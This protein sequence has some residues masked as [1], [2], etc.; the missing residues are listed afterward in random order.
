MIVFNQIVP[1]TPVRSHRKTPEQR[2]RSKNILYFLGRRQVCRAVF[3]STYGIS[4]A[5]IAYLV[6]RKSRDS[7]ALSPDRRGR[8]TPGNKTSPETE[9]SIK[10]FL[11]SFPRSAANQA[12][13]GGDNYG[14]DPQLTMRKMHRMYLE[15]NPGSKVSPFVFKKVFIEFGANNG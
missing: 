4:S 7:A 5:R 14:F 2:Q 12:R 11:A 3:L 13:S 6:N 8:H 10:A 15:G 1:Q 9:A